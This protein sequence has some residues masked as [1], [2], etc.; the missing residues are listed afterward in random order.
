MAAAQWSWISC[1]SASWVPWASGVWGPA[2]GWWSRRSVP[3]AAAGQ[4]GAG[5]HGCQQKCKSTLFHKIPLFSDVLKHWVLVVVS[6]AFMPD[7]LQ[8]LILI[9]GLHGVHQ[10]EV[11]PVRLALDLGKQVHAGYPDIRSKVFC[12]LAYSGSLPVSRAMA[13]WKS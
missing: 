11:V 9:P 4:G 13:I 3:A 12:T 10:P 8:C 2:L 7:E 5:H 6:P 1:F